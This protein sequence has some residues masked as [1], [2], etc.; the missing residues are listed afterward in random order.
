MTFAK[1]LLVWLFVMLLS[2]L[3][4][5]LRPDFLQYNTFIAGT[6]YSLYLWIPALFI[7]GIWADWK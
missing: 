4:F 5:G 1:A 6:A 2:M 7:G 3:I